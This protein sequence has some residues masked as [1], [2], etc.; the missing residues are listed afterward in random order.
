METNNIK[1]SGTAPDYTLPLSKYDNLTFADCVVQWIWD[2]IWSERLNLSDVPKPIRLFSDSIYISAFRID[3]Y[4]TPEK[5]LEDIHIMLSDYSDY[6]D[7]L[8]DHYS[9][10]LLRLS[11]VEGMN[12]GKE[13]VKNFWKNLEP[14]LKEKFRCAREHGEASIRTLL[15]DKLLEESGQ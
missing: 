15:A 12:N 3:C 9:T 13:A 1:E 14:E 8:E 6:P 5:Y 10:I 7:A 2:C 11:S 4:S